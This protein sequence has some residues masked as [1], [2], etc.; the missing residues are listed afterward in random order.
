M[1][2]SQNP[3]LHPLIDT[4]QT[5]N[6]ATDRPAYRPEETVPSGMDND[7]R[8]DEEIIDQTTETDG[9]SDTKL[10]FSDRVE[11]PARPAETPGLIPAL[12]D[13]P[14]TDDRLSEKLAYALAGAEPPV[15]EPEPR[16][17]THEGVT[18]ASLEDE[19]RDLRD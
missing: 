12:S 5:G 7:P 13:D 2:P 19:E 10:R 3:N 8:A 11:R 17:V 16:K 6:Q 14:A 4:P 9:G 15:G 1:T 18:G